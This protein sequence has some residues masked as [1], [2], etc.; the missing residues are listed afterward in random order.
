MR[1]ICFLCL[2][3]LSLWGCEPYTEIAFIDLEVNFTASSFLIQEGGQVTFIPITT[4]VAKKYFWDF[5]EANATSEEA[6]PIYQY[7]RR[8]V[9]AV[10]LVSTKADNIRKDSITKN[11]LVLPNTTS[12]EGFAS[13]YGQEGVDEVGSA[14]IQTQS[15]YVIAARRG[16]RSL[17]ILRM[18]NT[19]NVTAPPKSINNLSESNAQLFPTAILNTSDRGLV[20]VGY[21]AYN[22]GDRDAFIIKLDESGSEVWRRRRNTANDERYVAVLEVNNQY[23]VAGTVVSEQSQIVLDQYS[24]EGVPEGSTF[25]TG[26]TWAVQDFKATTDGGYVMAA[27]EGLNPF[28]IKLKP[29]LTIDWT[30][31]I[32]AFRGVGLGV[33]QLAS[34]DFAFVGLISTGTP[35][36]T[37]AFAARVS[38]A[39][40]LKWVRPFAMFHEY[41][42]DV[43]EVGTDL[44]V[45]GSHDN[46]LSKSD[47]LLCRYNANTGNLTE[48]VILLGDTN[49]N[50]AYRMNLREDGTTVTLSCIGATQESPTGQRN[51]YLLKKE[52]EAP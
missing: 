17:L 6:N 9:Y 7:N 32:E 42:S 28:I 1:K 2:F 39:G 21:Y 18:D 8:G 47:V 41:F 13:E 33:T 51:V 27:N 35:D 16:S 29:N 48:D 46:P 43:R 14:F 3:I 20:V 5:N 30:R 22:T 19:G 40:T 26:T 4:E 24:Q 49:N 38:D 45:L 10:K 12:D 52:I 11:V 37:H 25:F 23:F 34:N 31:S 36:S 50:Q 44:L 15:G